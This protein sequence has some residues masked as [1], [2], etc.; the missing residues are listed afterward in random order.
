MAKVFTDM[1]GSSYAKTESI[2]AVDLSG[3]GCRVV[4]GRP[5]NAV[6]SSIYLEEQRAVHPEG[7]LRAR[8]LTRGVSDLD[9]AAR[10]RR[11]DRLMKIAESWVWM[12]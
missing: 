11:E 3:L 4:N 2:G 5:F 9:Q 8:I 10:A 7:N 6:I 1:S 12:S